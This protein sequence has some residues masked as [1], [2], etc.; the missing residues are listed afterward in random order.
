LGDVAVVA[1]RPNERLSVAV[2]GAGGRLLASTQG[3]AAAR[4]FENK[5]AFVQIA[6][7]AG[8]PTPRWE[9]VVPGDSVP[10]AELAARLGPR[11]VAQAPRGNAGQRTWLI[12]GQE[13]LDRVRAVEGDS[14][15]RMAEQVDGLPFT[16]NGV[17][18]AGGLVA[19]SEPCRQTTGLDWLTP[20]ELGSSGNAFGDPALAQHAAATQ[21]SLAAIGG[22]LADAGYAGIFGVDFVLGPGGPLVIETNPRLVASLPLATQLEMAAG[23]VP[24]FLRHLLAVLGA[25]GRHPAG[26]PADPV[27]G[28]GASPGSPLGS[29]SQLLVRRLPGDPPVRPAMPSGVYRVATARPPEFLRDG[30]YLDDMAAADEALVFTRDQSESVSDGREFARIFVRG[31]AG[32]EHAGMSEVVAA[33]RGLPIE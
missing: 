14:P 12:D 13:A 6:A 33:L 18:G 24:L 7:E 11:L 8:V 4:R 17:A 9:V 30:L 27:G 21:G 31:P 2:E 5:L 32:E 25:H 1:V 22:A 28:A 10:Y 3:F 26:R 23:R 20:M 15:L 19:S 29:A 16:A